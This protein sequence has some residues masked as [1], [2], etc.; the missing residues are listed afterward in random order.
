MV[1]LGID[2]SAFAL[3]VE[4]NNCSYKGHECANNVIA[5]LLKKGQDAVNP[6]A[7]KIHNISALLTATCRRMILLL[8]EENPG[9]G[10]RPNGT[11]SR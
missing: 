9:A 5:G 7:G 10:S 8:Q 3:L 1:E 6:L 4:L 2:R 11:P